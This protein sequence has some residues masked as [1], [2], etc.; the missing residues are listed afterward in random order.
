MRLKMR[1]TRSMAWSCSEELGVPCV[2]L[3][4]ESFCV[5]DILRR[6]PGGVWI[7]DPPNQV[8]NT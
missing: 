5:D 1:T 2:E 6:F 8:L 3:R 7:S 4:K